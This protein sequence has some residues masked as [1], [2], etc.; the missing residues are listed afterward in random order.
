MPKS[1]VG[2]P[3]TARFVQALT[4]AES[5]ITALQRQLLVEHWL[6][7]SHTATAG[8]LAR[9]VG[10]KNYGAVNLHYGRLGTLLREELDYRGKGQKSSVIASFSKTGGTTG[11]EWDWH[12]HDQLA[13]AL[14]QVGWV[15]RPSKTSH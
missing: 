3:I 8:E 7:P 15:V 4:T 13:A 1:D 11:D 12:M 2:L 14:E 10:A 6:C 5:K 9:K